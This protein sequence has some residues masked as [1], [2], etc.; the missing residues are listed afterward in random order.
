MLHEP[1][2]A[3]LAV[4][5][6][7]RIP[8]LCAGRTRREMDAA[9]LQFRIDMR[10]A[11]RFE[12]DNEFVRL[13]TAAAY[14]KPEKVLS[15]IGVANLP[16]ET[17]WVEFNLHAKV[18]QSIDQGTAQHP[19]LEGVPSRYGLLLKRNPARR[20]AW[21]MTMVGELDLEG[22]HVVT[23]HPTSFKFDADE[24]LVSSDPDILCD[25]PRA[26]SA[27]AWGYL[28]AEE[29]NPVRRA[30]I[31]QLVR[32]GMPA[33]HPAYAGHFKRAI[34]TG[35]RSEIEAAQEAVLANANE[36][37]AL[38]RWTVTVLAML[39]EIPVRNDHVQPNGQHRARLNTSRPLMDFHRLT[40]KLPKTRQQAYVERKLNHLSWRNRAHEV[41][42]HWRTYPKPNMCA[43]HQWL[44][45]HQNGYRL[46]ETCEAF[47]R[48]IPE[49][50]RGDP[51]LG[52]VRKDY[53]VK[54]AA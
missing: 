19:T 53:V 2:L 21:H 23:V 14:N 30:A 12:L 8:G 16:Y 48:L 5:D 51:K 15:R 39:N 47:G 40:L 49:H 27:Y 35:I 45:D 52:W 18:Q 29:T 4:A 31:D 25:N 26:A 11:N 28:G 42:S 17:T 38:L 6:S 43:A 54:P 36:S 13:A 9:M 34:A 24:L 1:A 10:K 7:Y 22:Q 44:Y 3:D 37:V 41:L 46:C 32:H 20:S 50:V 33:I